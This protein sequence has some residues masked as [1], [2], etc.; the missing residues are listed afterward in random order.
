MV[1]ETHHIIVTLLKS[2]N[3]ET[4]KSIQEKITCKQMKRRETSNFLSEI[5]DKDTNMMLLKCWKKTPSK[6]NCISRENIILFYFSYFFLEFNL[7]FN[8]FYCCAGW[9]H[10]VAFTKVLTIYQTYHT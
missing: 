8:F 4:L 5:G 2:K 6:W 3:T 1:V 9:G 10:I 7:I